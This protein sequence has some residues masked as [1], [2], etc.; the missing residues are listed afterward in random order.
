[1]GTIVIQQPH[2]HVKIT[3][4]QSLQ[5]LL[6]RLNKCAQNYNLN[7][8][9]FIGKT[10]TPPTFIHHQ[11]ISHHTQYYLLESPYVYIVCVS[12]FQYKQSEHKIIYYNSP[13]IPPNA[14]SNPLHTRP[15]SIPFSHTPLEHRK[16]LLNISL[17]VLHIPLRYYMYNY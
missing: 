3:K 16:Y 6:A 2:H 11:H 7:I 13:I 17:D 10:T 4:V 14:S 5:S 8:Q 12:V 9:C 15:P 1:M